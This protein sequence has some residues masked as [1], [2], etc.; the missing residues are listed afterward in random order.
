MIW[1]TCCSS[2]QFIV[3]T[4]NLEVDVTPVP[5]CKIHWCQH[6]TSVHKRLI[7]CSHVVYHKSGWLLD[8]KVRVIGKIGC[9]GQG[10]LWVKLASHWF[11]NTVFDSLYLHCSYGLF[12]TGCV[13]P[14]QSHSGTVMAQYN[15]GG[16][17]R[18]VREGKCGIYHTKWKIII[19][20]ALQLQ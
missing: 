11:R 13:L 5:N 8:L 1:W 12:T 2:S 19:L 15:N 18:W 20:K 7:S 3:L 17:G 4:V 6:H 10:W 9:N 16:I 14:L